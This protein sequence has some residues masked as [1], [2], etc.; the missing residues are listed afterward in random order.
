MLRLKRK[1]KRAQV[2]KLFRSKILRISIMSLDKFGLIFHGNAGKRF[3]SN[4]PIVDV[5]THVMDTSKTPKKL[6]NF[7]Y[8]EVKPKVRFMAPVYLRGE[9]LTHPIDGGTCP[10]FELFFSMDCIQVYSR[11]IK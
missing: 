9:N 2:S 8:E 1:D 10:V 4:G 11:V 5:T 6:D 3:V 7:Y